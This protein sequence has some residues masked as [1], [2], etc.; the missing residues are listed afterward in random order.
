MAI[1]SLVQQFHDDELGEQLYYLVFDLAGD[2]IK[3]LLFG[4][5]KLF[6]L[7]T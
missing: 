1:K 2:I 5:F 6:K 7:I 4:E 3:A